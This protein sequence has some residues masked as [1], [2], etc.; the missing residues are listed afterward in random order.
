MPEIRAAGGKLR[1]GVPYRIEVRES[2]RVVKKATFQCRYAC[3]VSRVHGN[4]TSID[5]K[6]K[7]RYACNVSRVHA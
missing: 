1:L 3:N 6:Q 5:W 2:K 7:C 4:G